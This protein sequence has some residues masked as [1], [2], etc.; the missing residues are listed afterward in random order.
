[1]GSVREVR[2]WV[3]VVVVWYWGWHWSVFGWCEVGLV[4]GGCGL[5]RYGQ[6]PGEPASDVT[7]QASKHPN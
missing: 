7:K 3:S 4:F 2:C 5:C 1:M 6:A